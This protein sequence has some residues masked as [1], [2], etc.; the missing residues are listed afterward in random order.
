MRTYVRTCSVLYLFNYPLMWQ[1]LQSVHMHLL[2]PLFVWTLGLGRCVPGCCAQ[3]ACLR[4]QGK[5]C[6]AM[7]ASPRRPN[8]SIYDTIRSYPGLERWPLLIISSSRL[9]R[10][11]GGYADQ[12]TSNHGKLW[13]RRACHARQPKYIYSTI[14]LD[15]YKIDFLINISFSYNN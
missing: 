2:I 8:G 3:L 4:R 9:S 1:S 12:Q 7:A 15:L 6:M 13:R 5:A 11:R 10:G 14:V